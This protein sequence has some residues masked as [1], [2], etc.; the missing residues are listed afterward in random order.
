[1]PDVTSVVS[2]EAA[3]RLFAAG[4]A[5]DRLRVEGVLDFS[6]ASGRVL[7]AR[8]PRDLQV[9]VLNLSDREVETL[10]S[11][12]RAYELIAA[13]TL[14]RSLPADLNVQ[15]RL[16]LSRCDRLESLPRELTV[17]TLV[18]RGCN[19]LR[20]LPEGLDVWFLDLSGCWAFETWPHEARIR[21]G[22][23]RLRGCTAIRR[24]PPYLAN[25]AAVDVCDCPNLSELPDRL[26]ISGWLDLARSGLTNESQLPA[27][28]ERTSLRWAGVP[29]DRRIAFHPES[30]R[31]DE[32][33]QERNAERRRALLDRYGY[34]RFLKDAGAEVLDNDVDPG[35]ER[36][37]LKVAM[38]GDEDLVALSCYCP[39]TGRQYII[40]VPPATPTCRHAAAWVA[41]F[42]NPDD[43]RPVLE[44]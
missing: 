13:G 38:Q 30:I 41:G 15:T 23:L 36:Q 29:I 14:L 27:G 43:Y 16:D 44:T 28:L 1:M 20:A 5:P 9:D 26:R 32:V 3:Y 18:L 35:G 12:L 11:G 25:L 8:F 42:D 39:S 4:N 19:S 7:P 33:L 21:S 6:M 37:L 10:P 24:L 2:A 22:Q 31:V 34:G 17:G 40:R